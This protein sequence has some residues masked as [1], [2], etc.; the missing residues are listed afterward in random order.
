VHQQKKNKTAT[1]KLIKK[2]TNMD[3]RNSKKGD[4]PLISHCPWWQWLG[5]EGLQSPV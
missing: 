2:K 1:S 4:Q 3:F 5:A